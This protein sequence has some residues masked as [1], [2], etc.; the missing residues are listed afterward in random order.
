MDFKTLLAPL[1]LVLTAAASGLGLATFTADETSALAE[2]AEAIYVGVAGV[3]GTVAV[4]VKRTA[5]DKAKADSAGE[6]Q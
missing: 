2:H 4:A 5:A 6:G 1:A 3:I